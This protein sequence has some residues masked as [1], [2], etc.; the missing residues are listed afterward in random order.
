MHEVHLS[1]KAHN[2]LQKLEK[3]Q[4]DRVM[5][6]LAKL[7]QESV[8][9][10]AKFIK[11]EK[12]EAIFRLRIGGFR[13]LYKVIPVKEVVLVAKIDKRPTVYSR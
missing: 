8:P 13:S 3:A 10:D 5:R 9:Q 2:T 7:S 1:R 6:R 11:R 12:G 4:R